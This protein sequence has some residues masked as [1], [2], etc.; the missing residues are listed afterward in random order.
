MV[1]AEV[2]SCCV[3]G[4]DDGLLTL[5]FAVLFLYLA[6]GFMECT[7][8]SASTWSHHTGVLAI[9]DRLGGLET[10]LKTG[11]EA[12]RMLL[13]EFASAELTAAVI[14]GRRPSF[15]PAVWDT[16]D[17]GSVWWGRD[18]MGR[19]SLASVFKEMSGIAF[20]LDDTAHGLQE[21]SM[22]QVRI[23]EH[24][25]RPVYAPLSVQDLDSVDGCDDKSSVSDEDA[26]AFHAFTLM[27]AFQHGA[28]IFLYRALC[29]LPALHP[30]V[31][32]H[33]QSCLDSIF[34]IHR[35]SHVLNCVIFPLF[36]AGAHAKTAS[37]RTA[38]L[39]MVKLI[40]DDMRFASVQSVSRVFDDI[41]QNQVQNI[42]WTDMFAPLSP[43][44]LVL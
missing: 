16:I 22:D 38:V 5:L 41:W 25:L 29:G 34:E 9:L 36:V 24:A 33:V 30:L 7:N 39:D 21:L 1:R 35:P 23:F 37:Q 8:K 10:M 17:Q 20:Y 19:C 2:D 6:D 4:D 15:A 44:A 18:P 40:Y 28:L 26:E 42:S 3:R 11:P 12:L 43:H 14:Q 32:Q 27:R 13:S 31:Q